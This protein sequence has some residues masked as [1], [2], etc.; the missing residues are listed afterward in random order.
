MGAQIVNPEEVLVIVIH[1]LILIVSLQSIEVSLIFPSSV[2]LHLSVV[3]KLRT[4]LLNKTQIESW[5]VDKAIGRRKGKS[6]TSFVYPYDLGYWKNF[7][8]VCKSCIVRCNSAWQ[9]KYIHVQSNFSDSAILGADLLHFLM[10][11][12]FCV[13]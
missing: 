5:I 11:P 4:V 10:P 13:L 3:L 6:I 7:T 12:F 1:F 2:F 9:E 8:Q